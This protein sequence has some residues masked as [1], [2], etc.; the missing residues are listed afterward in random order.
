MSLLQGTTYG[1]SSKKIH[2][3]KTFVLPD[4]Y[5]LFN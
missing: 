2:L 1:L 5:N 4:F 3:A